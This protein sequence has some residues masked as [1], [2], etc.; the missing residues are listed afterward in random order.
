[1]KILLVDDDPEIVDLL[2][3]YLEL[4]GHEIHTAENGER[5]AAL[6]ADLAGFYGVAIVDFNMPVMN[7]VEFVKKIRALGDQTPVFILTGFAEQLPEDELAALGVHDV[8]S[9]PL[10]LYILNEAIGSLK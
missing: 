8:F 3:D 4:Y 5:A 7:G 9:K 6:I 1:M 2:S 10:P